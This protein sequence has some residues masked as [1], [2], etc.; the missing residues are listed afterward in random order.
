MP[1]E[2]GSVDV[3]MGMDGLTK[4]LAV[5][6][7]N[8]KLVRDRGGD[9]SDSRLNII[10]CTKTQKYIRKG[11]YV[12][13]AQINE[14]KT[15]ENLEKKRLEDEEKEEAAFQQ[16]KQKLCSALILALPEG[17]E[18]FM[19]YCDALNKGLGDVL[20]QKEK[21]IDY[22]SRKIKVH[23]KN[24]TT[25]DLELGEIVFAL[26]IWRHCLYDTKCIV[27]IDHK[28]LQHILDHK[29]LNMR[30]RQR[31]KLLSDY[32]CVI[33][34]HPRKANVVVDALSRKEWIKPL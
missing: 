3:I 15:G 17:M 14:K 28:D 30:Q 25:H 19:V 7:C 11:C 1:I 16:L 31:L 10:S 6:V 4:Y 24:Y 12:F 5:I 9:K 33:C 27:F 26:K 23:E 18:N 2:L 29:E 8:E 20:M 34:Y 21:V 22:A 13:L 32:D